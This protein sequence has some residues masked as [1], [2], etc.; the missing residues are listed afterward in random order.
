MQE[1]S[2]TKISDESRAGTVTFWQAIDRPNVQV[3]V[4][5]DL[6]LKGGPG[7]LLRGFGT[8]QPGESYLPP[9][10]LLHLAAP[11]ARP[12]G[13]GREGLFFQRDQTGDAYPCVG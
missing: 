12:E 8:Q 13:Y 6:R 3:S 2:R 7:F 4:T 11:Q 9:A 5:F 10:P 1:G